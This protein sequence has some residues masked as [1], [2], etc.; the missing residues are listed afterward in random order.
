MLQHLLVTFVD[1]AKL[2]FCD[3]RMNERIDGQTNV[4]VEIVIQISYDYSISVN[5]Q[6]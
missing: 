3:V 1:W 6:V 5:I 4:T 2:N